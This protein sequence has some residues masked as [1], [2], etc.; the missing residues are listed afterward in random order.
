MASS[1]LI[2]RLLIR[3]SNF[4]S[5]R[6]SQTLS[7]LLRNNDNTTNRYTIFL[8]QQQ[9]QQ[10]QHASKSYSGGAGTGDSGDDQRRYGSPLRK[11]GFVRERVDEGKKETRGSVAFRDVNGK[12]KDVFQAFDG[13]GQGEDEEAEEEDDEAEWKDQHQHS[14]LAENNPE[15]A[16]MQNLVGLGLSLPVA[17]LLSS[18]K[19]ASQLQHRRTFI[20]LKTN[21]EVADNSGARRVQCIKVLG[22]GKGARLGDTIIASVKDAAPRGKVKKGEV[23]YCVV[24]RAAMQKLRCDGSQIKFDGNAVVLVNKQLEPIGTRVFGP[25]SAELR[26]RKLDKVLA[27]AEQIA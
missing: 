16:T 27:L 11:A 18:P 25:I 26:Q 23:V 1:S 17:S 4:L 21:L 19:F 6:S 9:Q 5:P 8:R 10:Q 3:T 7:P 15:A 12:N 22:G 20:Q 2:A 14:H 13:E 24:V